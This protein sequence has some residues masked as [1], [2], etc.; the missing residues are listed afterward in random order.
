VVSCADYQFLVGPVASEHSQGNLK[1]GNYSQNG[2]IGK[3]INKFND[4]SMIIM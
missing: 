1:K 2:E 4:Y 3:V